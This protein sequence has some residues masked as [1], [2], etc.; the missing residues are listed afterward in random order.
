MIIKS[1]EVLK[2]A[3]LTT[4]SS[5]VNYPVSNILDSRLPTLYRTDANIEAAIVFYTGKAETISGISIAN[6]NISIGYDILKIQGNDTDVWT[7]PS[8][9]F[10]LTYGDI[11]DGVFP[12]ETYKYWRVQIIDS[13]NAN[14]YIQMGR[15]WIG[16]SYSTCGINVLVNEDRNTNS[17]KTVGLG[18]QTYGDKRYENI[19]TSVAFPVLNES[20]AQTIRDIF[21]TVDI[22]IPIFITFDKA[23]S[24][25]GTLYVTIDGNINIT[26]LGNRKLYTS[27]F[28]FRE[29]K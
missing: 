21:S 12:E 1:N 10:D 24:T 23:G 16:E 7:S 6:H 13:L 15:V 11:I 28:T 3:A 9:S 4:N 17:K 8:F 25:L 19:E 26:P 27:G 29:E 20:Q 14:G 22:I 5:L 18:G 2:D